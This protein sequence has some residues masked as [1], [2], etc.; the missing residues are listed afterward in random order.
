MAWSGFQWFKVLPPE[1]GEVEAEGE[2]EVD[3]E[4]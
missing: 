1:E 3:S 2:V 4:G